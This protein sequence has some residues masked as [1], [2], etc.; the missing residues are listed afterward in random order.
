[1]QFVHTTIQYLTGMGVKKKC[2]TNA[3]FFILLLAI[4]LAAACSRESEPAT[5]TEAPL[6]AGDPYCGRPVEDFEMATRM[7]LER[8]DNFPKPGEKA[9]PFS[10]P[11]AA[12]GKPTTLTELHRDQPLVIIFGSGSC[13]ALGRSEA[14]I[15]NFY[16]RYSP[17]FQ[18]AF[19]YIRE[20]HPTEGYQPRKYA[21]EITPLPDAEKIEERIHAAK[22]YAESRAI[23]FPVLVDRI[24]DEIARRYS[25]WPVRLFVVDR[26]G[27]VL[28][29]GG[30]APWFYRPFKAY[31]HKPP[32]EPILQSLPNTPISLEEFLDGRIRRN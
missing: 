27:T 17:Y 25:A 14:W 29:A 13:S 23:P 16:E 1:L 22:Q 32:E 7:I 12:T 15:L 21:K 19:V 2:K 31:R 4:S 6:S 26:E 9:L 18:F 8:A 5:E 24:D 11:N 20:S 10:L 3:G 28:Y 30:Q